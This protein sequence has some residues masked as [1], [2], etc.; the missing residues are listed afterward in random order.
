[1]AFLL[2]FPLLASSIVHAADVGTYNYTSS[3]KLSSAAISQFNASANTSWSQKIDSIIYDSPFNLTTVHPEYKVTL[4]ISEHASPE[5]TSDSSVTQSLIFV[6]PPANSG[7]GVGNDSTVRDWYSCAVVFKRITDA[8]TRRGEN[9]DGGC[10]PTLGGPC[11]DALYARVRETTDV[12]GR[13]ECGT[14]IREI[15]SEC[16]E[17]IAGG[18]GDFLSFDLNASSNS[19]DLVPLLLT[20]SESHSPA[21]K[22]YYDEASHRIWPVLVYQKVTS[23]GGDDWTQA[24]ASTQ[25]TCLRDHNAEKSVSG[26]QTT[27]ST[28]SSTATDK[29]GAGVKF[30]MEGKMWGVVLVALA[31]LMMGV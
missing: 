3:P 4:A 6:T 29:P 25:M 7:V 14:L 30:G 23:G 18:G 15:P 13:V 19:S 20:T 10:H 31:G 24:A 8:A 2:A 16:S 28:P 1:M 12:D 27:S 11:I 9:E 21:N 22:S 5:N 26:T 17:A